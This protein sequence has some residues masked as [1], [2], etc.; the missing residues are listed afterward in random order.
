[1]THINL[2]SVKSRG[3][4]I[5]DQVLGLR[6]LSNVLFTFFCLLWQNFP[7]Y[8]KN[9]SDRSN[10]RSGSMINISLTVEGKRLSLLAL[11]RLRLSEENTNIRI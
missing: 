10:I 8:E 1:M 11:E 4:C 9:I 7:V 6:L 2:E 3:Q 5:K